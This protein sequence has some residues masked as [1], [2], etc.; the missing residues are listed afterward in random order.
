MNRAQ[1]QKKKPRHA[2]ILIAALVC[3]TIVMALIGCMLLSALRTARQLRLER[4]L[5][6][7]E[8]LLTAGI[9]RAGHQIAKFSDY[10]GEIWRLPAEQITSA[11]TGEVTI[12]VLLESTANQSQLQVLA[13]YPLGSETSIR[14]SRT[15]FIPVTKPASQE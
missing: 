7:C 15:I 12:E 3:L 8:L 4:D 6:Q 13:E 10:R 5:R 11:G 1:R 9:G 2:S 14:R